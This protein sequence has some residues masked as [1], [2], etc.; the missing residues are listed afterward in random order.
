VSIKKSTLLTVVTKTEGFSGAD[1]AIL[2]RDALMAPIREIQR[3]RFFK[4]GTAKDKQGRQRDD[5][6]VVCK[7]T[8]QGA[9]ATTWDQLPP[10][11]VGVPLVMDRHFL[12]S[13]EKAKPSVGAADLQ[14]YERWTREFGEEGK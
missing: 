4:K 2:V 3:A 10:E 7:Q 14:M 13:L 1:V 11:D 12:K 9:V 5:L 8:D 6:W